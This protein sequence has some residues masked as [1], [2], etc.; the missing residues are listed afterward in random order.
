MCFLQDDDDDDDDE[1]SEEESEEE[2]EEAD[3]EEEITETE[4]TPAPTRATTATRSPARGAPQ[5]A[6]GKKAPQY[7]MFQA[8]TG[9][10]Q[11]T[12]PRRK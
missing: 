7:S 3:E 12:P 6:G 4:P 5:Q 11:Q 10:A 9:S 8:S 1:L 2:E